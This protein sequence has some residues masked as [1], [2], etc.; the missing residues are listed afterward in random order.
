MFLSF[1]HK[2]TKKFKPAKTIL[3]QPPRNIHKTPNFIDEFASPHRPH[4]AIAH[5][6][7]EMNV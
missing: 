6:S 1:E 3:Y 5:K 4:S 7:H 2:N